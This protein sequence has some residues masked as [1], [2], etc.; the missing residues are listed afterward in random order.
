M[1]TEGLPRWYG[2]CQKTCRRHAGNAGHRRTHR[3]VLGK[4]RLT[5]RQLVWRPEVA[6]DRATAQLPTQP[7]PTRLGVFVARKPSN[8]AAV[9]VQ[10]E[11]ESRPC[12]GWR[13][14]NTIAQLTGTRKQPDLKCADIT[15]RGCTVVTRL[16]ACAH[17]QN[18][19]GRI[20]VA[21][22]CNFALNRRV[23]QRG[24]KKTM[25]P[26]R[27]VHCVVL[28]LSAGEGT[29]APSSTVSAWLSSSAIARFWLGLVVVG[30]GVIAA[31]SVTRL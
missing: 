1:F 18:D 23:C 7:D 29:K 25:R 26:I 12:G 4:V 22:S 16:T 6:S 3:T 8:A 20:P 31:Q 19:H 14:G 15:Q 5:P 10:G 21:W 2:E 28:T 24:K 17:T 9:I 27:A 13:N 11:A 30:R